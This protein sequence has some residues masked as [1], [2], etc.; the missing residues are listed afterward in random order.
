[1]ASLQAGNDR[2]AHLAGLLE[3]AHL[4]LT[5]A[6]GAE[7]TMDA[8]I[9][10]PAA[11]LRTLRAEADAVKVELEAAA[12]HRGWRLGHLQF[13]CADPGARPAPGP[14]K[15]GEV[16]EGIACALAEW[17]AYEVEA[18]CDRLELPAAGPGADPWKSKRL[19]AR[20]RLQSFEVPELMRIARRVLEDVDDPELQA[21]IDRYRPQG[22][23]GPV[24]NLIF[25]STSK[26]DLV[27]VDA[28]SNDIGLVNPEAALIYDAGIP[29]EGLSW[30]D[31]VRALL[32]AETAADERAPARHLYRRLLACL[33]SEPERRFFRAYAERF[34]HSFDQPALIPQ[35]WMHYDPRS[36]RQRGDQPVLTTQRMDFL[37]LLAGGRRVVCEI[38]GK[39]HYTDA[40][41][42]PSPQ[43]YAQ[44][45]R[46]DRQL[47]LRGYEVYR[48][49]GAELPTDDA[50]LELVGEFF[51]N[52]FR[53][54][55]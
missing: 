34:K 2:Q 8:S 49:G 52:L 33:A 11:H 40:A 48:F 54:G 21:L 32:P 39:T 4:V 7:G 13:S 6:D 14:P 53:T 16:I 23:S 46:D 55:R 50:A 1:M 27:L 35:V 42:R 28:L 45:V 24:K 30:R 17:K 18:Y 31:I 9:A 10:V 41:G 51:D 37:L 26:P 38:D 5:A 47:R 12:E 15:R 3:G 19:Y 20:Q 43:R 36:R 22:P 29:D 44:M 25:G